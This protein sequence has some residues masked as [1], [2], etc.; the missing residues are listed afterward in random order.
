MSSQLENKKSFLLGAGLAVMLAGCAVTPVQPATSGGA[1]SAPVSPG[2]A[3]PAPVLQDQQPLQV[4]PP[5]VS[6]P[7]TPVLPPTVPPQVVP[8]VTPAP[9][10]ARVAAPYSSERDGRVLLDRLLPHGIP[11]RAGWHSDIINAFT[12][13]KLPYS[14]QNFCAVL[15]VAEQESS[16]DPDPVTPN[17]SAIV[18]GEIEK[19]RQKYLIPSL[20]VDAALAKTSPDGRSYKARINALRTKRQMNAL[21]EDMVRELPFGQTIFEHKN[22]IRDGGPMQ[23]SVAFAEMHVRGWPYPYSYKN[24][25]DE[26]FTRRG[27]V[28]F[29]AAI[30]L[31]YPM[32]YSDM[33]YRFADYNAGRYSS[34]N[35]AFQ[36][37]L[38]RVVHRK[39]ATDGDLMLYENKMER[40]PSGAASETQKVLLSIADRLHMSSG[41]ILRD[42]GQEKLAGFGQ[43]QLYRQVFALADA[44]AGRQVPRE[45]IPQIVLVSPKITHHLTTE[46]FARKVDGRYQNCLAR[47]G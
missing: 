30:M 47:G 36:A 18:W 33:V 23:V 31:Q 37:A 34:R 5:E 38:G 10:P 6:A 16:Y 4:S 43:T 41:E 27:S 19:R 9:A 22:P 46:W 24:L 29:G 1:T 14:P 11:D 7:V 40:I 17:L 39:L 28:Y 42:L 44:A 26:V 32:Q 45:A 25:R 35:A 8:P 12:H 2:V 13:L 15:A 20:V 3:L 21:F